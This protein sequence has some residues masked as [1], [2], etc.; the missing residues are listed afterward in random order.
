[1][2]K[3]KILFK[4]FNSK[5]NRQLFSLASLNQKIL[6]KRE[7]KKIVG[8]EICG[9]YCGTVGDCETFRQIDDYFN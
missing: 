2:V 6:K 5:K 3:T 9:C 4:M 1:M 8:G 7:M